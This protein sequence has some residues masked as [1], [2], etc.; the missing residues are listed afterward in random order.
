M[1]LPSGPSPTEPWSEAV[2]P[3]LAAAWPI[4][5]GY[6]PIGVALGVLAQKAGLRPFDA[7][8]M[9]LLVF[10]GSAQFIGISMLS[11]GAGPLSV[12]M[13]TFVVNLRHVL[14]SAALAVHLQGRSKGF[15]AL[16]AYGVTDESFALNMARFRAE[17]WNWRRALVV[18]TASN[19]AWI[20]ATIVGCHAGEL[21]PAG[22]FGIDYALT[23]MFICLLVLQM[24]TRLHILAAAVAGTLA[25]VLSLLM[26][27]NL[28][29]VIA[30]LAA[31]TI[32][33]PRGGGKKITPGER[34]GA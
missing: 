30:S 3:G 12:I 4:C 6:I 19:L 9:S 7:G 14:M 23:A 5:L 18:N 8:V 1:N 16:Y 22:A 17:G 11:A 24:R 33:L 31:A 21:I 28:Y 10:A 25:V 34:S 29:V 15:L 32:C 27:G 20:S 13:T 26:E 2:K